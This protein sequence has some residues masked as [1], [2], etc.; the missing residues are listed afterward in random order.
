VKASVLV[1]LGVGYVAG[2]RAGRGRYRQIVSGSQRLAAALEH[3][4]AGGRAAGPADR[5]HPGPR[6][7]DRGAGDGGGRAVTSETDQRG[8]DDEHDPT[9]RRL[10]PEVT[11]AGDTGRGIDDRFEEFERL[12]TMGPLL[13]RRTTE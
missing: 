7:D 5:P 3:Y 11:P 4:A 6:D 8:A 1:A 10:G 2:T 13:E 9:R 12:A